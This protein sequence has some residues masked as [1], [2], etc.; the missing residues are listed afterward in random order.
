MAG[1]EQAG[2][3]AAAHDLYARSLCLLVPPKP[4]PRRSLS[5]LRAFWLA[6][7]CNRV[8]EVSPRDQ[9]ELTAAASHLPHVTAVCLVNVLADAADKDPRALEVCATGFRDTTRIAAGLPGMWVDILSSNREAVCRGISQLQ[10]KLS[11][12]KQQL[13]KGARPALGRELERARTLRAQMEKP[14]R[15]R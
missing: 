14:R 3:T 6:V 15:A 12:V 11:R 5:R 13:Q 8:L 10:A 2:V 7:G 1:S 9:D 4:V